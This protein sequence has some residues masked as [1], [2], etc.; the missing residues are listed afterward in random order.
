LKK[1]RKPQ[2]ELFIE[3]TAEEKQI[4]TLLT[5]NQFLHIDELNQRTGLSNSTVASAILNLELQNL[6]SSLPGKRYQ[7]Q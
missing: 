6:V 7:L 5:E 1:E 4:V 3:L 2:R